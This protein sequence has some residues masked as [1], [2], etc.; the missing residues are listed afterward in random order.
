MNED[1]ISE[2]IEILKPYR[3]FISD[4]PKLVSLLYDI[5]MLPEQCQTVIGAIRLS[6]LCMVWQM[7]EE[8]TL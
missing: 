6:A 5:D 7:G 2:V 8:G 3:K 4:R 1:D